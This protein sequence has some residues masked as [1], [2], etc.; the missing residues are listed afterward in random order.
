[1]GE[2]QTISCSPKWHYSMPPAPGYPLTGSSPAE[3][4]SVSPGNW[5]LTDF[6]KTDDY[7]LLLRLR[8]GLEADGEN[9]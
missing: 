4:V 9:N 5:Y 1:M 7:C 3:P 2:H 6:A 8:R